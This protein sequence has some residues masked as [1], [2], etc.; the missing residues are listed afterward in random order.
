M[1]ALGSKSGCSTMLGKIMGRDVPNGWN[2]PTKGLCVMLPE[3]KEEPNICM[4][5]SC[6]N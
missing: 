4:D 3:N 1:A 5:V 6:M 2:K